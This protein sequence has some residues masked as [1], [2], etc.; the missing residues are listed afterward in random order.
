MWPPKTTF[1]TAVF[2]LL[3]PTIAWPDSSEERDELLEAEAPVEELVVPARGRIRL[4]A[5]EPG[6]VMEAAFEGEAW[7]PVEE[8]ILAPALGGPYLLRVAAVDEAGNRSRESTIRVL[9]DETAPE[10]ELSLDPPPVAAGDG[11]AP[12]VG[13]GSRAKAEA[14]DDA[15]G[16]DGFLLEDSTGQRATTA[17]STELI[18]PRD[19]AV[20]VRAEAT[21]GVG[22]RSESVVV[23][24][25][26]DS[27]GPVGEI[28]V[29]GPQIEGAAGLVVG[30]G[31][32]ID[33]KFTDHGSGLDSWSRRLDGRQVESQEWR[34]EALAPGTYRVAAEA[35]DRVGNR[36]LLT[37][38]EILVDKEG[39]ELVWK[40]ASA[41]VSGEE[42]AI[43]FRPPVT[44]EV[45]AHD[46]AAGVDRLEWSPDGSR[47][48]TLE[49]ASGSVEAD[50]ES[51]SM[52]A[53]DRVGN[54]REIRA[55]WRVD[56]APPEPRLRGP[57]G[58]APPPGSVLR[59]P[60]GSKL[61]AW[62]EDGGSGIAHQT[63]SLRRGHRLDA[64]YQYE[65]QTRGTY[66]LEVSAEDRLGNSV[67][68][69]WWV[70]VTRGAAQEMSHVE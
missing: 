59:L 4:L 70:C 21:D 6:A 57:F 17:P 38:Q 26:V 28:H 22:N 5:P 52:R 3:F 51:L 2:C 54:L 37:E 61:E 7:A 55:T 31:A 32:R 13:P 42:G 27:E 35:W 47:W 53:V 33:A 16:V 40:V 60:Q 23:K 43:F 63:V 67:K 24:V 18:L 48:S 15:S 10:V 39:P 66:R 49:A 36:T 62:A 14:R 19:G 20:E 69:H 12:W 44:V 68:E 64:P 29:E 45:S 8:E 41:G 34:A 65:L 1:L 50:G 9:V 30:A 11:G 56:L 25:R 46:K 58:E